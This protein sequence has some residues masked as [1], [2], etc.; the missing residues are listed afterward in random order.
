MSFKDKKIAV[1][2]VSDNKNK[3]GYKI[4]SSLVENG[5]DVYGINPKLETLE[6][7]KIYHSLSEIPQ[8]PDIVITVV[9]PSV[10]EQIVDECQ[11]LGINHIWF[12]PGSESEK[13]VKKAKSYG[14]ETTEACFMVQNDIWK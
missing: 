5:Y 8:K 13:A 7:R 4:F 6:G 12:Q 3:Y 1:V 11:R 2:G 14:I 9:P 10:S